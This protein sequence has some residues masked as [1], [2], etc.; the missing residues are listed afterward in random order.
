MV[1]ITKNQRLTKEDLD[2]AL[3]YSW[4]EPLEFKLTIT[5]IAY[6]RKRLLM[7]ALIIYNFK[8][9]S[10]ALSFLIEALEMCF[11]FSNYF[12]FNPQIAIWLDWLDCYKKDLNQKD[13]IDRLLQ[14]VLSKLSLDIKQVR[15]C[16][17]F[18]T[19]RREANYKVKGLVNYIN[20]LDNINTVF[21][22]KVV[23]EYR[24][25]TAAKLDLTDFLDKRLLAEYNQVF[26]GLVGY[27]WDIDRTDI[28][29]KSSVSVILIFDKA[30]DKETYQKRAYA[31][32]KVYKAEQGKTQC[33]FSST[34]MPT[35]NANYSLV[36]HEQGIQALQSLVNYFSFK[37]FYLESDPNLLS[38]HDKQSKT[39]KHRLFGRGKLE[40]S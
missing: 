20:S 35:D 31:I 13:H 21:Y 24:S 12:I 34:F 40:S 1:K 28:S 26:E 4:Y 6:D 29:E 32:A 19:L 27:F 5:N 10:Q 2:I 14:P 7:A 38:D 22:F 23:G 16:K 15:S 36:E 8:E 25:I 18:L 3:P 39:K 33:F 37:G 17:E 9:K 30:F 11:K